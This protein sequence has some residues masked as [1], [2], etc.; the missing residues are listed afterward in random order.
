MKKTLLVLTSVV[1]AACILL[2]GCNRKGR[3]NTSDPHY[4]IEISI[5]HETAGHPQ[6]SANNPIYR[7]L[8]DKLHVTFKWDIL[9]GDAKQKQ[10]VMI[11]GGD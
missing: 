7:Y 4:P 5:F 6:P 8:K 10:G 3:V 1:L 9:V 2:A 11:A